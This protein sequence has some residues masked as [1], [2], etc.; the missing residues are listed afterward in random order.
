MIDRLFVIL[1]AGASHDCV[2]S[3]ASVPVDEH[4]WPP[5]TPD[6]F[7]AKRRGYAEVLAKYPLIKAA[8]AELSSI[9]S[10]IGIEA[11]LRER[12]RDS[13]HGHDQQIFRGVLPYL[14]ELLYTVSEKFTVFPQNY[15]ALIAQLLRFNEV[16]FISLN[17]DVLLD[18]ALLAYDTNKTALDWYVRQPRN[19][20]LIK[21]HGSVDWGVLIP[22]VDGMQTFTAPK[23][24]LICRIVCQVGVF[25]RVRWAGGLGWSGERGAGLGVGVASL[26]MRGLGTPGPGFVLPACAV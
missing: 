12:Y 18:N 4:Y 25:D 22:A 16:T 2:S 19:W 6:L 20:S 5:L 3:E 9:G 24:D 7:T 1:G 15:E 21:L 23:D 26:M 8:A 13:E 14:Q 17:Y 10:A 11:E